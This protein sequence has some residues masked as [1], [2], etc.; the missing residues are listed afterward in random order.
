MMNVN[1]VAN[2]RVCRYWT[3]EKCAVKR[4]GGSGGFFVSLLG[5]ANA[6][7]RFIPAGFQYRILYSS[8][9]ERR[10]FYSVLKRF[11]GLGFALSEPEKTQLKSQKIKVN[12]LVIGGGISGISAALEGAAY[13]QSVLLVDSMQEL[14][15]EFRQRWNFTTIIE[16]L[17]KKMDI[18][19][20]HIDLLS[21]TP[22]VRV[23]LG[24]TVVAYYRIENVFLAVSESSTYELEADSVVISTGSHEI[25][26]VFDG[27]DSPRV[28]L[29]AAAQTLLKSETDFAS[30]AF[31]LDMDGTGIDL[32][33]SMKVEGLIID[34]IA[35]AT[36][37]SEL[38]RSICDRNKIPYFNESLITRV[39]NNGKIT[40]ESKSGLANSKTDLVIISA[41]HQPNYELAMQIGCTVNCRYQN[42][43]ISIIQN[44]R[45]FPFRV[46]LAGAVLGYFTFEECIESGKDSIA[47]LSA[48]KLGVGSTLTV[49]LDP[50]EYLA[51]ALSRKSLNSFVCLCED[52]SMREILS[53]ISE[54]Y[55]WVESVKRYTGVLTGPC[56]GKQ[57]ALTV[58]CI[59]S[60]MTQPKD[61]DTEMTSAAQGPNNKRYLTTVRQPLCP[62]SLSRLPE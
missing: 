15:G 46:S 2:V 38:E 36:S 9:I 26:P 20:R 17:R 39:Q 25:L 30:H 6:V 16:D 58:A 54:G 52:V 61:N 48:D 1:G 45:D 14:G 32:A 53:A 49:S 24:T 22:S 33:I 3:D 18:L 35:R 34:G 19:N 59:L 7:H 56:Q 4:Q 51:R 42:R 23:L 21:K 57:C 41:R 44:K 62:I 55:D 37:F 5:L 8:R 50:D 28:M 27:N 13:F 43:N 40:L 31:V 11:T 10:L 12:L 29:S 47:Q 60:T